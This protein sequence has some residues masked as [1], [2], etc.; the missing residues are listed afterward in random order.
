[1]TTAKYKGNQKIFLG[2]SFLLVDQ[3]LFKLIFSCVSVFKKVTVLLF[4]W[5][6]CKATGNVVNRS[7]FLIRF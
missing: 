2:S 1:M 3:D 5:F 7:L 6:S 4:F